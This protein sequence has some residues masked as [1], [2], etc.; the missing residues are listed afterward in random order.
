MTDIPITYAEFINV[1]KRLITEIKE[2]LLDSERKFLLSIKLGEPDWSLM[3]GLN[4]QNLPAL[5][6]KVMNVQRMDKTK[7]QAAIGKSA[8]GRAY[9][10]SGPQVRADEFHPSDLPQEMASCA[11]ITPTPR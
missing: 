10:T 7:H 11:V 3:P 2:T 8:T 1:R 5:K 9:W 4:L 6:W